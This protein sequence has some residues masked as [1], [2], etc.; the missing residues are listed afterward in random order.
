LPVAATGAVY[1]YVPEARRFEAIRHT[2]AELADGWL[3]HEGV[4][5]ADRTPIMSLFADKFLIDT[6]VVAAIGTFSSAAA[7]KATAKSADKTGKDAA[8]SAKPAAVDPLQAALVKSGWLLVGVGAPNQAGEFVKTV[9]AVSSRPKI[10]AE[11]KD[12]LAALAPKDETRTKWITGLA[13]K[14]AAAPKELPKGSLA[15]ELAIAHDAPSEAS[16]GAPAT[17]KPKAQ[18]APAKVY[19]FVVP[20]ASQTW[21]A[22]GA[23]KAELTKIALAALE[24]APESGTLAARQDISAFRQSKLAVGGFWT[25]EAM[26]HSLLAP[27]SWADGEVAQNTQNADVLLA[28]TPGKGKT[29]ISCTEEITTGD[30]TNI[31]VRTVVPK[32]VIEDAVLLAAGSGLSR[33]LP[34]P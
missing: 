7:V 13:L 22:F 30:G 26:L 20:E 11:V 19:L 32:G 18:P 21:L 25:L 3:Q 31:T 4:A 15:F 16:A 33:H 23:D 12:Q 10:Q 8:K 28:T 5:P 27:A 34:R 17:R 29:P 9:A 1:E 2:A 14:A 6:P 24:G